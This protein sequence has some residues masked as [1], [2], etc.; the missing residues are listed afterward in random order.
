[1]RRLIQRPS[2]RLRLVLRLFSHAPVSVHMRSARLPTQSHSHVKKAGQAVLTLDG[3]WADR[4]R[5]AWPTR[6]GRPT[7]PGRGFGT[8]PRVLTNH[9]AR[10]S[11]CWTRVQKNVG[12]SVLETHRPIGSLCCSRAYTFRPKLRMPKEAPFREDA[13]RRKGQTPGPGFEGN[14]TAIPGLSGKRIWS[15]YVCVCMGLTA[16]AFVSMPLCVLYIV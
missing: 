9:V 16:S 14:E 2:T 6:H 8:G 4:R 10:T 12:T 13:A 15:I 1:M 11:D 3:E 5:L 7:R